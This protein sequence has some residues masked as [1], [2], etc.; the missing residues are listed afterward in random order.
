VYE[1]YAEL[2]AWQKLQRRLHAGVKTD[3]GDPEY[4]VNSGLTLYHSL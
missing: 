3:A 2:T 4:A 1:G